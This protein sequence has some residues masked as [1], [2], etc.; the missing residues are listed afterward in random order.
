MVVSVAITQLEGSAAHMQR[1]VPQA[2][3]WVANFIVIMQMGV[4]VAIIQVAFSAVLYAHDCF[5][6]NYV[7][8]SFFYG[9]VGDS[10][11]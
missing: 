3:M 11:K 10:F 6:C 4:S 2:N 5:Y 8:D 9:Y 7:F 1:T